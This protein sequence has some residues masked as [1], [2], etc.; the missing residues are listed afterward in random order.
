MMCTGFVNLHLQ[1]GARFFLFLC[2]FT[3]LWLLTPA[4]PD[5][6]AIDASE[7]MIISLCLFV[8]VKMFVALFRLG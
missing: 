6:N 8:L 1:I 2:F 3:S 5:T 7:T 4:K